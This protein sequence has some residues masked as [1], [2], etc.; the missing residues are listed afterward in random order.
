MNFTAQDRA[1]L[2]KV[3]AK[4]NGKVT[5]FQD[6]DLNAMLEQG[7]EAAS[8]SELSE[9]ALLPR[10][11]V[12]VLMEAYNNSASPELGLLP[13]LSCQSVVQFAVAVI[14]VHPSLHCT[15]TCTHM[16]KVW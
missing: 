2:R 8:W 14:L 16:S 7:L 5:A 12:R 11:P 9:K 4:I 3:R 15:C 13:A 10:V 1:D 6:T